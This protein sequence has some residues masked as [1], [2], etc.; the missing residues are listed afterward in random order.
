MLSSTD[1]VTVAETIMQRCNWK[2]MPTCIVSGTTN[3]CFPQVSYTAPRQ[4]GGAGTEILEEHN[5]HQ[6]AVRGGHVWLAHRPRPALLEHQRP[7]H[8]PGLRQRGL[9]GQDRGRQHGL[10]V[11]RH[12]EDN[13]RL[14]HGG[15]GPVQHQLPS[16]WR[17]QDVVLDTAGAWP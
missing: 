13:V 15:H 8:D 10:P 16:L 1:I 6:P 14:A 11:L 17:T 3:W 9:R 7:R 4:H 5:V 2:D 12:V